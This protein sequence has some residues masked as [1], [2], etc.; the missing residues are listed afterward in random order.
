VSTKVLWS[1]WSESL[2]TWTST[3]ASNLL[4]SLVV[5]A[6]YLLLTRLALPRIEARVDQSNLKAEA[7]KKAYHMVRLL[8]GIV[9]LSILL[10]VWGIDFSGLLVISTSLLTVTGVALFANWSLLSNVTAYFVLLFHN[11]FRRGNFVRV[12]DVDNYMEGYIAEVN[13]FNT[14]LI[15]ED[16]EVV[17]Y[18]NN[19]ILPR[20]TIINPRDRWQTLGKV[21]DKPKM[22]FNEDSLLKKGEAA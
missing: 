2:T 18:P 19:L 15:T 16:R 6:L 3:Y 12:I 11:S 8:T 4:L 1:N 20:P 22:E 17:V 14:K 9:T 10:I 13:L 21:T 5:V 7:T